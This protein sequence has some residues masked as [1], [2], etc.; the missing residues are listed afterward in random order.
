MKETIKVLSFF[1][2]TYAVFF[3][4]QVVGMYKTGKFLNNAE[5]KEVAHLKEVCKELEDA[6]QELKETIKA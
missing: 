3:G 2:A 4:G 5:G 6:I 1:G